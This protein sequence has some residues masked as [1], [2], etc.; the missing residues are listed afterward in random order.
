MKTQ[1]TFRDFKGFDHL[2][3]YVQSTIDQTLGKLDLSRYADV[4]VIIGTDHARHTDGKS[5]NFLCEVTL[6]VKSQKIFVKK[7][8]ADFQA[9][10]RKCMKAASDILVKKTTARRHK[11]RRG[12][13]SMAQMSY[14][15]SYS[16]STT[17]I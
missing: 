4:N 17:E 11:I 2:R 14:G 5:P 3:E 12:I 16:P 8:D 9:S 6:K 13:A 7:I 15:A 1:I 10:V